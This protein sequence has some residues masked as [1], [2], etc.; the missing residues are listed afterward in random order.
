[1]LCMFNKTKFKIMKNYHKIKQNL[2]DFKNDDKQLK[3]IARKN[4]KILNFFLIKYIN[5][6][7]QFLVLLNIIIQDKIYKNSST[8]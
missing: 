4:R 8:D 5:A 7:I 1:M 2:L 6:L 3:I